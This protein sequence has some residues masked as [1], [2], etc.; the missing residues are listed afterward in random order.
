MKIVADEN[1]PLLREFFADLGDIVTRP[2]RGMTAADVADADVLLVRSVTRVD[3]ALL[4]GSRVRFVGTATIGMDHLDL[5]WLHG[6]GISVA[7]AP[8]CN[9]RAVAEYVV[10]ALLEL[11][12][13]QDFR[14]V[15]K[16]VGVVGLGNVGSRLARLAKALGYRVLGCDPFVSHAD[17]EQ[18]P[19]QELQARADIL[20]LHTPLTK[21]GPHPTRHLLGAEGLGRLKPG[22][23]VLNAGRGAVVDNAALLA[24][25]EQ[26]GM[27][28]V[29]D[30]WE[31]EPVIS[32]A[33][34]DKVRYGSPHIAGYSQEGK[35][36]GT[37]QV[38]EA[39]CAH[40]GREPV[41]SFTDFVPAMAAEVLQVPAGLS[42]R[43]AALHV[44]R[45]AYPLARDD[46][47]LRAAQ[48]EVDP[49]A[50]FDALR[51]HYWPRREFAS[52]RVRLDAGH[53][54]WPL[55]ASLGFQPA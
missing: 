18:C 28:A 15:D 52:H 12:A 17:I 38:Y 3:R 2:G 48:Q 49:A 10:T 51:K 21:E 32:A 11:G 45:A 6:A 1:M 16:T 34:L 47:A 13:E 33:L 19:W 35:W 39:L 8:G 24:R 55:L 25:L 23:I 5:A 42:A 29:L 7:S 41:H 27:T 53:A 50:A 30:V 46:A 36:R 44:V 4:E 31:G 26:G 43:D 9:A 22:A 14:P 40:L 37:A 54:A 20:C